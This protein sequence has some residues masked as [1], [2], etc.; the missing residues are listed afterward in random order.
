ML[1]RRAT[2]PDTN[3]VLKEVLQPAAYAPGEGVITTY[4]FGTYAA[5]WGTSFSTPFVSGTVA[6]LRSI[7]TSLNQ[8]LA[9]EA[10][11]NATYISPALGYGRLDI[12]RAAV[13][14]C[15]TTHRC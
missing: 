11:S 4:P 9:A 8:A 6:L 12:Y 15:A 2:V 14:W 7:D 1:R 3:G 5:G 13:A 10:V